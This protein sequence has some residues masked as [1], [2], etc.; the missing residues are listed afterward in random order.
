MRMYVCVYV[1]KF[2]RH[3]FWILALPDLLTTHKLH[4]TENAVPLFAIENWHE[5]IEENLLDM[6]YRWSELLPLLGEVSVP[7]CYFGKQSSKSLQNLQIHVFVDASEKAYA[8]VAYVRLTCANEIKCAFVASKTKV[9]PLKHLSIPRLELQA[10]MIGARLIQTI[11]SSLTLPI[12]GRYLW[13]NSATVLAWV[14][15]DTRRYHPFIGFRVGEILSVTNVEEWRYIP[16]H[17]NVADEATKWTAGPS[18]N[19]NHRWFKG[20]SFLSKPDFN[21]PK[22]AIQAVAIAA[23]SL[24]LAESGVPVTRHRS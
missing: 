2:C 16:S 11:S 1:Y 18:F 10:A 22:E 7:R 4:S 5:P 20:P 23:S 15:S 6:W 17:L 12:G 14:R 3:T 9:A 21:W 19:P 13:T 24:R 8:C